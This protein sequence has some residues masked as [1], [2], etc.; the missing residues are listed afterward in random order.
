MKQA[1]TLLFFLQIWTAAAQPAFRYSYGAIVRGDTTSPRM[2]IVFT[3]HEFADGGSSI[4]STLKKNALKASFFLTGDFYRNP[5]FEE[6]IGQLRQNGH[7]LGAHSDA[8]LLY[9][10]WNRRDSLL[11]TQKQFADDLTA[12]YTA[13]FPFGIQAAD[14]PHFLPPFEWYNDTIAAWTRQLGIQ[15]INFSPGTRS[16]ADYTWPQLPNYRSSR[17]ILQSIRRFERT[18]PAG[19]NGFILLLHIGTDPRRTDK[20]YR[21]LP[22]LL[23]FLKVRGYQPVRVDELLIR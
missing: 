14:A 20:F 7:Y 10:D 5:D 2:A 12:N 3:G 9:C 4:A 11:V 23:R 15:L 6:L 1:L 8:H 19:L 16:A 21:K 13:M 17:A 18:A 22:A